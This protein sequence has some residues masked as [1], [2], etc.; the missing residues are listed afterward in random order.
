MYLNY[1]SFKLKVYF[2]KM[3]G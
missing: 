2:Q 1:Y 3:F